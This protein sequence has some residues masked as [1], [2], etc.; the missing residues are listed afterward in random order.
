MMRA[1]A[2]RSTDIVRV[3]EQLDTLRTKKRDRNARIAADPFSFVRSIN[4]N[5]GGSQSRKRGRGRDDDE[6]QDG[7]AIEAEVDMGPSPAENESINIKK[8]RI[9][10]HLD[11]LG[12]TYFEAR[13]NH[14]QLPLQQ[15]TERLS[16]VCRFIKHHRSHDRMARFTHSLT[17]SLDCRH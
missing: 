13:K 5:A 9:V 2:V 10:S 4:P 12:S 8:R 1:L 14:S 3:R 6:Q 17:R 15:F 11:A 16:A 7:D